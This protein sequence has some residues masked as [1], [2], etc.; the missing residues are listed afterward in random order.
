LACDESRRLNRSLH[1]CHRLCDRHIELRRGNLH[2]L[3]RLVRLR[4]GWRLRPN[5]KAG[6]H[7]S[8]SLVLPFSKRHAT[9]QRPL[10]NG[11]RRIPRRRSAT[12]ARP[13]MPGQ[14]Q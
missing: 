5:E 9:E 10:S 12:I 6:L 14:S 13:D 1:V 11:D 3:G 8:H 4:C 7:P 2:W